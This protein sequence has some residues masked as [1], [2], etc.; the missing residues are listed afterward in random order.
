MRERRGA[1]KVLMRKPEEKRPHGRHWR[2]CENKIK[3]EIQQVAWA[4]WSGLI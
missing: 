3:M 1:Y 4:A 2:R